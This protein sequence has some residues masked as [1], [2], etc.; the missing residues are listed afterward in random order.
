MKSLKDAGSRDLDAVRSRALRLAG[1]GR[2]TS[3]DAKEVADR[4]DALKTYIGSIDEI[5]PDT[6]EN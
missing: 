3:E 2:V 5:D 6:K 1:L 4:C